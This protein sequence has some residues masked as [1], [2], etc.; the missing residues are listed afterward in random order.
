MTDALAATAAWNRHSVPQGTSAYVPFCAR[1]GSRGVMFGVRVM[2]RPDRQSVMHVAV[3]REGFDGGGLEPA[4]SCQD[5][6]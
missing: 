5:L 2:A 6:G 1:T 3:G 4:P